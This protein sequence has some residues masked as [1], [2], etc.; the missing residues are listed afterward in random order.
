LNTSILSRRERSYLYN[1]L[2]RLV[3]DNCG[4]S[5]PTAAFHR[6]VQRAGLDAQEQGHPMVS[7]V[8]ALAAIFFET[9]SPAA[10]L[11]GEH[12]ITRQDVVALIAKAADKGTG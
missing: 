3:V 11:L 2:K 4:D 6:V 12:G 10:R 5:K 7:G 1:E 9:R 8:Y